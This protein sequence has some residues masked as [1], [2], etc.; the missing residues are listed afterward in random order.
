MKLVIKNNKVLATHDNNQEIESLY[1]DC[2]FVIND[3]FAGQVG[4]EYEITEEQEKAQKKLEILAQID[5]LE[6]TQARAIREVALN[7]SVDFAMGKLQ[8]LD[9]QIAELRKML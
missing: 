4:D 8:L 7:K 2:S 9:E 5:E 3:N 1:P 6:K